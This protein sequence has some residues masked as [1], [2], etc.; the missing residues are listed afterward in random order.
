MSAP[1]SGVAGAAPHAASLAPRFGIYVHIPYCLSVCPYCDFNVYVGDGDDA[2][3]Y[4][5][6]VLIET[7]ARAGEARSK[8]VV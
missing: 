4:L 2:A 6:A 1:R 3:R 7:R 8:S 5:D